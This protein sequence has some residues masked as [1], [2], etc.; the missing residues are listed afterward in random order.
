MLKQVA[1]PR[2]LRLPEVLAMKGMSKTCIYTRIKDGAFS[3]QN[4]LGSHSVV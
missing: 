4:Q 3:K 2:F 1:P